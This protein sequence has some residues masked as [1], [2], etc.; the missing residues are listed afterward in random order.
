[1]SQ[2]TVEAILKATDSSWTKGFSQ[3]ESKVDGFSSKLGSV[4]KGVGKVAAAG[5]AAVGAATGAAAVKGTKDF[6][7]FEKGMNEVFTLL[8]GM[9]DKAMGDMSGHVKDFS[10][11][12]GTLPDEVV[13]AL[14][15]SI[16]AGVPPDNV[17]SFLETAQ[18]AAVGG[19]TD[20]NTAVDGISS[21]V[22]A[23]GD[24]VMDA[25]SASDL[26][27]SAVKLGKTDFEQLSN[28]LYNVIPTASS[29][30]V[31][32]GDVT[33]ALATMTAQGTPTS[34]A[35]TQ[36]RQALVELSKDG[37][38]AS[39]TFQEI[40]GKSFKDFVAEGGNV[41][42]ALQLMEK[43]AE[44]TGV[45]VNDLF[46][47][48]EAGN[49]ALALTGSG[50]E[51][52]SEALAEMDKSAGATEAA[53]DQMEQ[54]LGRSFEKIQAAMSVMSINIGDKFAPYV[55]RFAEM[56]VEWMPVIE[57]K[58][59]SAIDTVLSWL[60]TLAE[61]TFVQSFIEVIQMAADR[62]GE[63]GNSPIWETI[64]NV[65]G[66]VAQ[67][68]LNIDFTEVVAGIANFLERWS[69][70]IAGVAGAIATFGAIVGVIK[71]IAAAKLLWAGAVALL[72][73]PF[74]LAA[75]AVGVL[76]AIGVALW[77]NWDT[78]KAKAAELHERVKTAV[79]NMVQAVVQFFQNLHTR[80]Q[81]TVQNMVAAVV[82]FFVNLHHR[83]QSTVQN[84]VASAVNFFRNLHVSIQSTVQ[85]MVASVVNFFVNLHQRIQSTVQNLV[86]SVVNFFRNLGSS[87]LS[88]ISGMVSGVINFISNMRS[89]I[90]STV[91]NIRSTFT[92]IF[93]SLAGIVTGA[94]GR[95]VSNVRSGITR[96]FNVITGF[97]GKFKNAGANIIG[98][99]AKGITGA[100]G[101][102]TDAVGGVMKKA[103][104]LLPFSPPKDKSSPLVDIHKNG[105]TEQI[106]KGIYNGENEIDKAMN[107][108]L[109]SDAFDMH[110]H[111][112]AQGS[113][114]NRTNSS[115]AQS[116]NNGRIEMLLE[117][118]LNKDQNFYMDG[119]ALVGSTFD[120]YN[121]F[122]GNR[123]ENEERWDR[124]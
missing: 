44:E 30:G 108:V 27:F 100:I 69:P 75:A 76:I 8:P 11:Q 91:N 82:N 41:Q 79:Q 90:V 51:T 115:N 13:P 88:I 56:F 55:A 62:V 15:S 72:T 103:R 94:F 74:F 63:F 3:A 12:F 112:Q 120:R 42:D 64:K 35:T 73:N 57:E 25:T 5:M 98:N 96:A 80:V 28:S 6:I 95:V 123:T 17:F 58:V 7:G 77:K 37:G 65:L 71:A 121:Q 47:S 119:D 116:Q 110:A 54:G 104:D 124:A 78:I 23:Y 83:V 31:E 60:R 22:N 106:A 20:L 113:Y 111:V 81:T 93:N 122:G 33:A 107:S 10:K 1:M 52:F 117:Q 40:S 87:A 59:M 29:L 48:V 49:A 85:N 86:A 99:I 2:F 114:A 34:V 109:S 32:F 97:F 68:I 4:M 43:H 67:A 50:T 70:L 118:L 38:K 46:G 66:Q 61:S 21:V 14:Y 45:G 19:V 39:D 101:K 53:Y 18:K 26:M 92:N 9:S 16:S 36:M 102:V 105:I 24:D 89:N 84:L